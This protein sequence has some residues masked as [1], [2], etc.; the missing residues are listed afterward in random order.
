MT[1]LIRYLLLAGL[2]AVLVTGLLGCKHEVTGQ[3]VMPDNGS[4]D[5]KRQA[6]IKWHQEHDKPTTGGAQQSGQ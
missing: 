3:N 6:M 4:P 1:Q 5:Q 2:A